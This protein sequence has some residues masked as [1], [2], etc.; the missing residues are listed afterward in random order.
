[1]LD[2]LIRSSWGYKKIK[3]EG[4][5]EG[6]Q[7]GLQQGLQKAL[8][9]LRLTLLEVVRGRFPALEPVAKKT[10]KAINEPAILRH[11]VVQLSMA[12]SEEMAKQAL[13]LQEKS[14]D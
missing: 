6:R 3:R 14:K 11:M 5:E 8:E 2:D 9:D 12:E 4:L 10:A 7:E 13:L 1:M